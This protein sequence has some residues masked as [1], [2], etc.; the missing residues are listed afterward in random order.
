MS[1]EQAR[2]LYRK[3]NYKEAKQ[4]LKELVSNFPQNHKYHHKF[5]CTLEWLTE[6][7]LAQHHYKLAL[8]LSNEN[9]MLYISDYAYFLMYCTGDLKSCKY[10]INKLENC[11][12]SSLEDKIRIAIYYGHTKQK[13]KCIEKFE[14]MLKSNPNHSS[15]T[16]LYACRLHKFGLYDKSLLLLNKCLS[17]NDNQNGQ[18]Y[19]L[20]GIIHYE[21]GNTTK[22]V[23]FLM[24]DKDTI[25]RSILF[26]V[27][28]HSCN[29]KK[30]NELS[31]YIKFEN[32]SISPAV[33]GYYEWKINNN[34]KLAEI[35][36]NEALN[37]YPKY[38]IDTYYRFTVNIS[39]IYFLLGKFYHYS[40]KYD[41]NKS[42]GYY[43]KC[44]KYREYFPEIYH[45]KSLLLFK[46]NKCIE[47]LKS[48]EK[49]YSI[50]K[51]V[52]IIKNNYQTLKNKLLLK[53]IDLLIDYWC[54]NK[55]NNQ[56]SICLDVKRIIVSFCQNMTT[57][58]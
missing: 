4:I 33:K 50:N 31:N 22:S 35:L 6:Y 13:E 42:L 9:I 20:L 19:F 49:G 52:K 38:K 44:I 15:V 23:E 24:K 34:E 1:F 8:S 27:L 39:F 29:N 58:I 2:K 53:I 46:M 43:N 18:V 36:M 10:Y 5:A 55:M 16:F 25:A 11:K 26:Y 12:D 37:K 28:I 7:T 57:F 32:N 56:S 17:L 3:K 48:L 45:H 40:S 14:Q 30:I 51:N 41:D 21:L 47:S 54:H